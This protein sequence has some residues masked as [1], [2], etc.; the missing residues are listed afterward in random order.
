MNKIA[1]LE[2]AETNWYQ[3]S[4]QKKKR[5]LLPSMNNEKKIQNLY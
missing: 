3:Y 4:I 5:I 2:A 1:L